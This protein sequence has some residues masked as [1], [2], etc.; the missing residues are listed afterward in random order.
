MCIFDGNRDLARMALSKYDC[1]LADRL[2]E[3]FKLRDYLR[4]GKLAHQIKGM[5]GYIA[6]KEAQ[7]LAL[8]LEQ[9]AK[10]LGEAQTSDFLVQEV[11]DSLHAV[12]VELEQ[13]VTPSVATALRELTEGG[14][15]PT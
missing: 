7:R 10:A 15:P 3:L 9:G 6:A 2:R 8:R 5:M 1:K 12:C 11:S 14:P 4:L 13:R